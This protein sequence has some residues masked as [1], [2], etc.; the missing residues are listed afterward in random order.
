MPRLCGMSGLPFLF[1]ILTLSLPKGK[2]PRIGRC[3]CFCS[4]E[5]AWGF[6]LG[7]SANSDNLPY[8]GFFSSQ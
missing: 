8:A 5:G 7:P 3:R 6:S 1:V 2:N 4:S